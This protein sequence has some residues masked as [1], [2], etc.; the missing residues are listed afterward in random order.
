MGPT[1]TLLARPI[2]AAGISANA[3]TVAS[4]AAGLAAGIMIAAGHSWIALAFIL[5]SRLGDGLDGAVA[6]IR[7]GTD[8]G[9]YM[10]IVFD[11][12]YY[13]AVPLGFVFYDPGTNGV[14]GAVLLFSFYV[15]GASFL[16]YAI[17]AEKRGMRTDARGQKS[18]FFTT[19][20]AEAGETLIIFVLAC[21]NPSWFPPLAY[22]FAAVTLYTAASRVVLA[23][24]VFRP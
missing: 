18:L 24:R 3:I 14:A 20:L 2:S 11:F 1:L 21:L 17:M 22:F 15:N 23:T 16:A 13:G 8:L 10:D 4:L 19:G 6:R 5:L 12:F 9:G 7:G